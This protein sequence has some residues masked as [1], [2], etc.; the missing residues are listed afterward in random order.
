MN[1]TTGSFGAHRVS[2]LAWPDVEA[3]L[4]QGA[5]ALVPVGAAS[6]EHGPHLPLGTDA[7]QAEYY[8]DAVAGALDALAWPVVGY[9]YYPVFTA[10][11]GSV[12]LRQETFEAMV[13]EI[14]DGIDAAGASRIAILN[15][16]ISTIAPLEAV[17]AARASKPRTGLVNCYAGP[18]FASAVAEVEEQPFGGHAD[19]IETS[20][21]LAIDPRRVATE[22]AVAQPTRIVRGLFNRA[23]P[24]APN[25]SPSG[26]NGDPTRASAAKGERLLA[27]LLEDVLAA[28]EA[29]ARG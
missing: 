10:Y 15:T 12:S 16:G 24:G 7:L 23:D 28:V 4:A 26:V 29:L 20:L 17:L 22:R 6:K 9:G 19:E 25:Y 2:D 3:R 11:P 13:A 8:A 27:A 21:M 18:R 5:I 14:L 1:A